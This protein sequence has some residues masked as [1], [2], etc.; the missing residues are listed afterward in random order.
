MFVV[1]NWAWPQWTVIIS[2]LI[3]ISLGIGFHG[4]KTTTTR[5]VGASFIA[6]PIMVAILAFG[7]FFA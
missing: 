6:I 2:S 5:S 4:K 7:G 3:T 1:E